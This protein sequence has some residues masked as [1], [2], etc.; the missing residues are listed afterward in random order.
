M[1]S[2]EI[3]LVLTKRFCEDKIK[4][5]GKD[6]FFVTGPRSMTKKN[7]EMDRVVRESRKFCTT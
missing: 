3:Y 6:P 2:Q 4:T 5:H 1:N 7:S